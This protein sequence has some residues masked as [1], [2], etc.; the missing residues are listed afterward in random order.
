VFPRAVTARLIGY[1]MLLVAVT[2][3]GAGALPSPPGSPAPVAQTPVP[4]GPPIATLLGL[5]GG[6]VTG[7]LGTFSWDGIASDAPWVVGRA[8]GKAQARA[9]LAVTFP[10]DAGE[11]A[12]RARW[13][14]LN[15]NQPGTPIDGGSGG[16]IAIELNPPRTP[17]PWSLQLVVDFGPGR[18]ATW[19]WRVEVAP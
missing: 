2:A 12:W 19:Y 9:A 15:G 11:T 18:S 1:A 4:A 16:R 3:C 10:A 6:G 5:S 13:A 8:T 17:G 7:D 14:P